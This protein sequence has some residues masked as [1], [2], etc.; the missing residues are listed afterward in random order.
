[1]TS[2]QD[3][4]WASA[5]AAASVRLYVTSASTDRPATIFV[6]YATGR[7]KKDDPFEISLHFGSL[8]RDPLRRD[9]TVNGGGGLRRTVAR[10]RRPGDCFI[11]RLY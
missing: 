4:I 1:M 2:C 7:E 8:A 9:A 3:R 11:T 10:I 5:A 6:I